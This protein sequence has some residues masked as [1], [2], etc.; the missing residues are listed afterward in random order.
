MGK[1]L[2]GL[3]RMLVIV[4]KLKGSSSGIPVEELER[5][6]TLRMEERGYTGVNLRTLQRDL[7]KRMNKNGT[8]TKNYC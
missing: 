7:L 2:E 8:A 3:Q 5:Y 6:V 1:R 4:N